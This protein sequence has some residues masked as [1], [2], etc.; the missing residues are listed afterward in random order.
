VRPI[1]SYQGQL[2]HVFLKD[3]SYRWIVT[4]V[5]T[6]DSLADSTAEEIL[7][8]LSDEPGYRFGY[9]Q[10]DGID[11]DP[12]H[13]PYRLDALSPAVF[14]HVTAAQS[15]D[16][17][18]KWLDY[19]VEQDG[20]LD[21]SKIQGDPGAAFDLVRSADACYYLRDLGPDAWRPLGG[22]VGKWDFTSSY[23]LVPTITSQ[24]C[25][26]VTIKP[27]SYHR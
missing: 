13:G 20:P 12:I 26:Q 8:V 22:I 10:P 11:T 16:I 14:D 2:D 18:R 4:R 1:L 15:E 19:F 24:S 7:T 3:Q 5:F 6:T 17:L 21:E 23:Y 9:D 25:P 27:A